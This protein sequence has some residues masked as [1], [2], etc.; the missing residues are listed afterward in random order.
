MKFEGYILQTYE[1]TEGTVQEANLKRLTKEALERIFKLTDD[2]ASLTREEKK[3]VK[4]FSGTNR[5]RFKIFI[6][7]PYA[8]LN[9]VSK[10]LA[11]EWQPP[12]QTRKDIHVVLTDEDELVPPV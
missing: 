3:H 8:D 10:A 2:T 9:R 7:I 11:M 4:V 6:H 5:G 1:D 12:F